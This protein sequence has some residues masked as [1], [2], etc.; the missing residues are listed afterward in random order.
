MNTLIS[1]SLGTEGFYTSCYYSGHWYSKWVSKDGNI[2]IGNLPFDEMPDLEETGPH[3][4]HHV[5]W[6]IGT[7]AQFA[8]EVMMLHESETE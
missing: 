5:R 3:I 8:R 1:L 2:V 4:N 7:L 6:E